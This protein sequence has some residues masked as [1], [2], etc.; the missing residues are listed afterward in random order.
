MPL[1]Y[2]LRVPLF[3]QS[4]H[5][6]C[7]PACL[8]MVLGYFGVKKSERELV[9]LT[10]ATQ[11]SGIGARGLLKAARQLGF[12]GFA[13]DSATF[14]D[15]RNCVMR[16]RIP[17]IVDWF[18]E[19]DGHYSVVVGIDRERIVLADPENGRRRAMPLSVFRRVWFDYVPDAPRKP[20]DF[21]VRRL[22]V[23]RPQGRAPK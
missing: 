23:F 17:V 13:K 20:G 14:G 6:Y 4:A 7:G 18:S 15:L 12:R 1:P 10:G 5:G 8:K 2:M 19:D 11:K 16:R 3:E 22:I 21:V 9:R